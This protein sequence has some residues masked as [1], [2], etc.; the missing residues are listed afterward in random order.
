[1]TPA[2]AVAARGEAYRPPTGDELLRR[3]RG[4]GTARPRV[5]PGLAFG[6]RDWLEDGLAE[7]AVAMADVDGPIRVT[8]ESLTGV[9]L[10]EAHLVAA[11][12]GPRRVTVELARGVLVD[13]VFRQWVTT[14][15]LADPWPEALEALSVGGDDDEVAA[16]VAALPAAER[17]ALAEE[18]AAQAQAIASRWPVPVAGFLGRTQERVA[19]PVAGGTVVL[20]G[21]LDL[22]FG[23]PAGDE[24]TVCV[25]EIKSGRRRIDHR[26]DLHFYALLETLR[27]G[28]APFRI[29]TYYTATGELDAEVVT[30]DV[31]VGAVPRVLAGA[32]ALCR[33]AGG[34]EPR[35][36][37]N[38]L[39]AWCGDLPVC[40][41]GQERAGSAVT[42]VGPAS[43]PDMLEE[44]GEGGRSGP[45]PVGEGVAIAGRGR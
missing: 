35:R 33:L 10:C 17:H 28:A 32:V 31:L 11:R 40:E 41:A 25:V 15:R 42:R 36:T 23:G 12:R 14:G 37:P 38:G 45:G 21:V 3:L 20:A 16:F 13:A 18:V 19:V 2:A 8:K 6:L 26:A 24:A 9:L 4:T 43:P 29:A 5:D 34:A 27:S 1:V 30:E 22:V 7:A 39:C 44:D